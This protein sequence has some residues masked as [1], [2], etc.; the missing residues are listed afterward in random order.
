M[1]LV[2]LTRLEDKENFKV[3]VEY[4]LHLCKRVYAEMHSA[5]QN[6]HQRGEEGGPGGWGTFS[7]AQKRHQGRAL[8]YREVFT[9]LLPVLTGSM[10]KPE[11]VIIVED[12]QGE[13]T[14]EY[15]TDVETIDLYNTM[16][17]TV[18]A[19]CALEF[20]AD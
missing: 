10:A 9:A 19:A 7:F 17:Q 4:W 8:L 16:R 13:L 14:K 5:T 12:E 11:E 18:G 20:E 1:Y 3:C 15:L 2:A 6:T